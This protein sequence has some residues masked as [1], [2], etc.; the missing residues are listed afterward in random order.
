M[1]YILNTGKYSAIMDTIIDLLVAISAKR[2]RRDVG[3]VFEFPLGAR[4]RD[5]MS[6][7]K[8]WK[9]FNVVKPLKA[10]QCIRMDKK[11]K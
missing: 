7:G 3:F 2:E 11:H 9:G 5:I 8:G 10:L 4:K 1:L 6:G